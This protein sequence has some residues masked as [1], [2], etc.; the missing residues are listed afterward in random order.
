MAQI[1]NLL[2]EKIK[3]FVKEL[4]KEKLNIAMFFLFGVMQEIRKMNGAILI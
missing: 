2:I 3:L 4:E 1:S